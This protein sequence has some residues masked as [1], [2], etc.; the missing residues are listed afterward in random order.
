MPRDTCIQLLIRLRRLVHEIKKSTDENATQLKEMIKQFSDTSKN[1]FEAL[2]ESHASLFDLIS[3]MLESV[4]P[5]PEADPLAWLSC[6]NY[7]VQY[8][9]YISRRQEGT[10]AWLLESEEFETWIAT[11]TETPVLFCPGPPGAGKTTLAA[12]VVEYLRLKFQDQ[13][14]TIVTHLYCNFR[15][16]QKTEHMLAGLAKQLLSDPSRP[17]ENLEKLRKQCQDERRQPRLGEAADLIRSSMPLYARVFVIVD[18]LDECVETDGNQEHLLSQLLQL[19]S[20]CKFRLFA[21]SRPI[22]R[23][24]ARFQDPNIAKLEIRATE[25]DIRMYVEANL[26]RLPSFVSK[27]GLLQEE[28]KKSILSSTDGM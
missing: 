22:P 27:D 5:G 14:D 20:Q 21:T 15:H 13:D 16:R 24:Q 23:I 12:T 4:H 7:Q 8:A 11:D 1:E 6:D 10:G 2:R 26:S 9:E 3:R 17:P 18:A 19:Q 25:H 28:I